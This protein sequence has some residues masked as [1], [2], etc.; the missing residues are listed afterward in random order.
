MPPSKHLL[1]SH[2]ATLHLVNSPMWRKS[3]SFKFHRDIDKPPT[4]SMYASI[5]DPPRTSAKSTSPA[6]YPTEYLCRHRLR[7]NPHTRRRPSQTNNLYPTSVKYSL[8]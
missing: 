6:L 4:S 8:L 1:Y 2:C 5:I 3:S 7:E